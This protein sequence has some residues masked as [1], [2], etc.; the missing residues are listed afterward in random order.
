MNRGGHFILVGAAVLGLWSGCATSRR[1]PAPEIVVPA[2]FSMAGE[3]AAAGD[4]WRMVGDP[5]LTELVAQAL[6]ANLDLRGVWDRLDQARAVAARE[7]A[8]SRP[9]LNLGGGGAAQAADRKPGDRRAVDGARD[10][11]FRRTGCQLRTGP[12]GTDRALQDAAAYELGVAALDVQ[13]AAIS[14]SAELASTWYQWIEALGQV[15]LLRDQLA[16]NQDLLML[17]ESRFQQGQVGATDVLQQ[18]QIVEAR[19]GHVA[20]AESAAV[21]LSHRLNLLAGLPPGRPLPPPPVALPSLPP[22]PATGVPAELMRRR[23]DVHR[24]HLLALAA[25]ERTQ[26]AIADRFPRIQLTG[27][28]SSS[29]ASAGSL[30]E[31]WLAS[32]AGDLVAPMLDGGRRRAEVTRNRAVVSQR[33]HEY[34]QVVLESLEDVENALVRERK[35]AEMLESLRRQL[36]LV[37]PDHRSASPAAMPEA[38]RISCAS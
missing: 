4:W 38:T 14:L 23:P 1:D 24:A 11:L 22:L 29:G 25:D 32:V 36:A 5:G 17:I 2:Q 33:F 26:A 10:R 31:T 21:T 6:Q 19:R 12:V 13:A 20:G 18:R 34:G 35:Q 15:R 30:F 8:A 7:N 3:S 37:R 28:L 16:T 9:V 27:Q